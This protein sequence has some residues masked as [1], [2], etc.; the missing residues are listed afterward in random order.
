MKLYISENGIDKE[1]IGVIF[2]TAKKSNKEITLENLKKILS[3]VGKIG[4][5]WE[6]EAEGITRTGK[7]HGV[8]I[9]ETFY[10]DGIHGY[11]DCVE[12]DSDD[13]EDEIQEGTVEKLF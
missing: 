1:E 3:R 2:A 9:Y 13:W 6:V 4:G 7:H 11:L 10:F 12:H 8:T 5:I